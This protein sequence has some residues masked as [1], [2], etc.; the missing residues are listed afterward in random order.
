MLRWLSGIVV[1]PAALP[2]K[3]VVE[4]VAVVALNE[5]PEELSFLMKISF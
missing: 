5:S 2:P 4:A 3:L 1:V